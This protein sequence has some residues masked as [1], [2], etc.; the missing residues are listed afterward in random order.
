[1]NN[2]SFANNSQIQSKKKDPLMIHV[3]LIAYCEHLNKI[4]VAYLGVVRVFEFE[5]KEKVES[6]Y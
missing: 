4:Y 3:P 2:N 1:M 5:K 6:L